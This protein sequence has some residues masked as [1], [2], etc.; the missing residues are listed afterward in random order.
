[1]W[2][3]FV[4][5][6]GGNTK[7]YIFSN[8][9]YTTGDGLTWEPVN[10]KPPMLEL[11]E[12]EKSHELSLALQRNQVPELLNWLLGRS[13]Y[14]DIDF[15]KI[16]ENG[17]WSTIFSGRVSKFTIDLHYLTLSVESIISY[18]MRSANRF[19]L[20]PGCVHL[21]GDSGCGV[22]MTNY[23]VMGSIESITDSTVTL[24]VTYRAPNV[25]PTPPENWYQFGTIE[26][27]GEIR[28]IVGST[29]DTLTLKFAFN[30]VS[31]GDAFTAYPGCD[32]RVD[33]CETKFN[34]KANFLGFPYAP[35]EE[36]VFKGKTGGV[37]EGSG[38]S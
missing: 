12:V 23:K 1:M 33:T 25:P 26:A 29:Y 7:R 9:K 10:G 35:F 20:N 11:N 6:Y 17:N 8:T 18:G 30:S 37:D 5:K 19:R 38:S 31:A 4:A 36:L 14:M 16:D 28:M 32:K 34:N 24:N 27:A 22:D 15:C 13:G 2:D 21:L 3:A